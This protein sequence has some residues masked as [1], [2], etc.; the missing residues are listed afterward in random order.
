MRWIFRV[1]EGI[2]LLIIRQEGRVVHRQVL[3]LKQ[4]TLNVLRI[5]GPPIEYCYLLTS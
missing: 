4:T 2:D 5:L 1:F 3:D